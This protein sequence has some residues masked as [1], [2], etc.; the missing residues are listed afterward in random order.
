MF[1]S[2]VLFL[3]PVKQLWRKGGVFRL[4][5]RISNTS[6]VNVVYP[7][8][9]FGCQAPVELLRE[10]KQATF[11]SHRWSPEMNIWHA[12]ILVSPRFLN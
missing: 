11:L 1:V 7:E 4:K 3:F 8:L 10:L 9:Q 5:L 12:R 2:A 6:L